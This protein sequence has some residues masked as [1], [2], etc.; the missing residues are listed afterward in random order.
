MLI[1]LEELYISDNK[2]GD[3]G[4]EL[5]SQGIANTKTLRV[6]EINCNNIGSSGSTT[7]GDALL[8]ND[9]GTICM[10]DNTIGHDGAKALST[11]I[12]N[13]Q[14]LKKWSLCSEDDSYRRP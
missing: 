3:H 12:I 14:K 6:L 8:T 5:I 11:A 9:R 1:Y 7:I 13:H 4:A 10:G 2:L